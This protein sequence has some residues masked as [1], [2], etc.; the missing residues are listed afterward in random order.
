MKNE[1]QDRLGDLARGFDFQ[2]SQL[3]EHRRELF[4]K[5]RDGDKSV[6]KRLEQ[7]KEKQTALS[8]ERSK[9]MLR[10]ETLPELLEIGDLRRISISIVV[11]DPSEEAKEAFDRDIEAMAMRI[12][13]NYEVDHYSAKVFDVSNPRLGKGYDLESHRANGEKVAIEV[14]GRASRSVVH[15]TENEWPTAANVRDKYY[16]YTV[17]DCASTPQLFRVQDPFGK[18]LVKSQ[19]SFTINPGQIIREAEPE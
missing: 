4:R 18:L 17:F 1:S 7:V 5:L 8:E 2:M 11:P 14:K 15:M 10:E 3:A 9:M 13:I 12:A 19:Q 16:L 6:E